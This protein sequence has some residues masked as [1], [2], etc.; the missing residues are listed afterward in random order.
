MHFRADLHIHSCL[1]PCADLEMGPQ[2]VVERALEQGLTHIAIT[3]HNSTR[4]CRAFQAVAEKAGLNFICGVE[5]TS[6][7]EAHI[8]CYFPNVEQAEACG[9]YVE[10]T[11]L[12][13]PLPDGMGEQI[14]INADEEI[15]EFIEDLY[16][17]VATSLTI[18]DILLFR[19]QFGATIVPA[20]VDKPIFSL[21]SQLGFIPNEPFDALEISTGGMR[22]GRDSDFSGYPIICASDAHY[23]ENIGDCYWEGDIADGNR[24]FSSTI[25]PTRIV[26]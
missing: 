12:P 25:I 5:I 14:V 10:S 26:K 13:I 22:S 20:H 8:L 17:S 16:L 2:A 6:T 18:D 15:E 3:D 7:E 19:E 21:E 24:L 9:N 4:N 23:I 11:L 1:S